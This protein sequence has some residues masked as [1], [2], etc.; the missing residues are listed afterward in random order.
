MSTLYSHRK[1]NNDAL[2]GWRDD[3]AAAGRADDT[4]TVRMSHARRCVEHIDKPV[5]TATREDLA[6]WLA[7]GKWG[8]AARRSARTS[9]RLFWRWM[10]ATGRVAEDV[11]DGLPTVLQPRPTP[12]PVPDV[13]VMDAIRQAPA[14]TALAIE[15]MATC[16]LRP[17]Q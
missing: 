16:G 1:T 8:P 2:R 12:R 17:G 3:L 15:I 6:G 9:I 4:I 5:S 14:R 11:A 7:R 13:I 10:A